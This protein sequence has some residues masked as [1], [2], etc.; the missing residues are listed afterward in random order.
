MNATQTPAEPIPAADFYNTEYLV[1]QMHR[2]RR[3]KNL[4][5]GALACLLTLSFLLLL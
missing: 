1:T 3:S 2:G 5:V 4:L